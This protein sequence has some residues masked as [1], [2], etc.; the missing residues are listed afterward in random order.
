MT[1][2]I[3]E[4]EGPPARVRVVA[5]V[6]L[7]WGVVGLFGLA[8]FS[9]RQMGGAA[10]PDLLAGRSPL[11]IGIAALAAAGSLAAGVLLWRGRRTGAFIALA[12]LAASLIDHVTRDRPLSLDAILTMIAM[13]LLVTAWKELR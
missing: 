3:D 6:F 2:R 7:F 11:R 12:A 13:V 5:T 8:F 9:I 4:E 1:T 10:M